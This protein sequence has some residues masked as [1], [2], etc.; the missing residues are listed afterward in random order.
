MTK[1]LQDGIAYGI[2]TEKEICEI[3]DSDW[4]KKMLSD[5]LGAMMKADMKLTEKQFMKKHGME[6]KWYGSEREESK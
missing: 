3:L 4:G 6:G 1:G 5:G 2:L